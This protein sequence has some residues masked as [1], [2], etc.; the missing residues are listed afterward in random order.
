MLWFRSSSKRCCP[1]ESSTLFGLGVGLHLVLVSSR[2][3]LVKVV[4]TTSL[5]G[6]YPVGNSTKRCRRRHATCGPIAQMDSRPVKAVLRRRCFQWNLR[7]LKADWIIFIGPRWWA[8]EQAINLVCS[9]NRHS[10]IFGKELEMHHIYAAFRGCGGLKFCKIV[11]AFLASIWDTF[12]SSCLRFY[13]GRTY[14][15]QYTGGAL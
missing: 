7:V 5:L 1:L 2:A 3:D 15:V 10:V 4:L 11:T 13:W 14:L 9:L 12:K 6:T 8:A